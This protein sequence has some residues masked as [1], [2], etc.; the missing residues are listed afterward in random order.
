MRGK[1]KL[2]ARAKQFALEHGLSG[3]T[4]RV[5]GSSVSIMLLGVGS[6][7]IFLFFARDIY[8]GSGDLAWHYSLIEFIVE[9]SALPG[10]DVARL[11]PMTEYPPGAHVFVAVVTSLFGVN[12]LRV[13]FLSS[14]VAVFVGYF[15]VL[16]LLGVQNRTECF[17]STVLM[18]F[19]IVLLRGTHMLFG[20]E[21]IQEYF[22]YSQLVGDLCFVFLLIV[23]SKIRHPAIVCVFAIVAVYALAW[24]YTASAAKLAV[25]IC[26]VQVLSLARG[27]SRERV[28]LLIALA[29]LLSLTIVTHPTFEPMVRNAAHDG[30]ISTALPFVLSGSALLL[31]LA[32][33]IWWLH[34]RSGSSTQCEPLV[35]AG[36]AIGLLAW[37]QFGFLRLAGLGSPY[38]VKKHGFMIGTFVAASL[39]AWFTAMLLR[40]GLYR[41]IRGSLTIIPVYVTRWIA[42]CLAV[43]AVLPWRGEPLDPVIKYDREVRAMVASGRP[44]DLLGH[45]ISVNRELPFVINLAVAFAVLELPGW[46]S[47]QI[48]QFAV[49]GMAE[50]MPSG[51]RYAVTVS[52]ISHPPPECVVEDYARMQIQLIRRDCIEA[53]SVH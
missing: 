51:V 44:P 49:F 18:I 7:G 23:A 12:A 4:T 42:A 10:A 46:T 27:Y 53:M 50:P 39:A 21:I 47:A 20:N 33:G 37:V 29:L 26:L 3:S 30:S 32:P 41:H 34:W 1:Q 24:I 52:T 31:L 45:T 35:A 11:G 8:T 9:H 14:I 28:L 25:S 15:L 13:L 40:S 19:F 36:V 2:T 17:A 5:L 48:D 22:F 38:A 6:I 43:V 16:N